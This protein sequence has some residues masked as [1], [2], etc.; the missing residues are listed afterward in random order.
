MP[1]PTW[2]GPGRAGPPAPPQAKTAVRGDAAPPRGSAS[3]RR[4][5]AFTLVE[6]LVVMAIIGL[7]AGT[8]LTAVSQ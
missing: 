2:C 1:R 3:R 6:L 4:G 5:S 8:T 7:L